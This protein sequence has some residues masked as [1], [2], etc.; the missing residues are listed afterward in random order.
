MTSWISKRFIKGK[1]LCVQSQQERSLDSSTKP[2]TEVH[3]GTENWSRPRTPGFLIP[4]PPVFLKP[5]CLQGK[6]PGCL[7]APANVPSMQVSPSDQKT[8]WLVTTWLPCAPPPDGTAHGGSPAP[9]LTGCGT[10]GQS[11]HLSEHQVSHAQHEGLK[12]TSCGKGATP[13][14]DS[15]ALELDDVSWVWRRRFK[16]SKSLV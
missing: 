15:A 13:T 9:P 4:P 14:R 1:L 3:R 7:R 16:L 2:N 6:E 10:S 5:T 11:S 8:A 12:H